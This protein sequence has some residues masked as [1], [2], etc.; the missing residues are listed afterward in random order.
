MDVAG[1]VVVDIGLTARQGE[2]VGQPCAV[3]G[4]ENRAGPVLLPA[5]ALTGLSALGCHE[6]APAVVADNPG[7]V[8][9]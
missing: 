8:G 4:G 5:E 7:V 6:P 9:S 1:E 3:I 2:F